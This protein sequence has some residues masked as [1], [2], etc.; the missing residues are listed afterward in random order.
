MKELVVVATLEV[1]VEPCAV[2]Q[3]T[4]LLIEGN[5]AETISML[6]TIRPRIQGLR[7]IVKDDAE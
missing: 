6:T 2:K 1:E 7:Y 5:A 3:M 4:L